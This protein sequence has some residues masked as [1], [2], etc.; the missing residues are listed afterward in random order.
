MRL[1]KFLCVLNIGSRSQVKELIRRGK[2]SVNNTVVKTADL[3]IDEKKD[4][5]CV[6]GQTLSYRKFYYYMLNKPAGVVSA[7]QDNLS[8][9]VIL[10]L[11]HI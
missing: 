5:V 1:D 3:K 8:D 9:T 6:Q 11:I 7:T 4:I 10:S 2:I